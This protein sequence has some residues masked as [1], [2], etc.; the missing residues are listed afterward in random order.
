MHDSDLLSTI[1]SP[2][3]I[4]PLKQNS[5]LPL[6]PW[7]NREFS[8]FD[9]LPGCNRAIVI[10]DDYCVLD[11]EGPGKQVS[12]ISHLQGL[13]QAHG[14]LPETLCWTTPSGGYAYLFKCSVPVEHKSLARTLGLELRTGQHYHLI[15]DSVVNGKPYR[16]EPVGEIAEIPAWL[17]DVFEAARTPLRSQESSTPSKQSRS[18]FIF[19]ALQQLNPTCSYEQWVRIGMACKAGGLTLE[20]W[21]QW[22]LKGENKCEDEAEYTRK[23]NSFTKSGVSEGTLIHMAMQTRW[24]PPREEVHLPAPTPKVLPEERFL[25]SFPEP[26]GLLKELKDYFLEVSKQEQYSL[27]AALFCMNVV[28]QRSYNFVS[29][30]QNSYHVFIGESGAR[31]STVMDTCFDVLRAVAPTLEMQDPRSVASF[32]KQLAEN[33]SRALAI[34]EIGFELNRALYSRKTSQQTED[35][36]KEILKMHGRPSH[37]AGHGTAKKED[38]V[39]GVLDPRISLCAT[40]TQSDFEE[41]LSHKD[42]VDTGLFSRFVVWRGLELPVSRFVF[43]QNKKTVPPDLVERLKR[44]HHAFAV[45]NTAWAPENVIVAHDVENYLADFKEREIDPLYAKHVRAR[46]LVERSFYQGIQFAYLHALGRDAPCLEVLDTEWGSEVALQV[47][48]QSLEAFELYEKDAVDLAIEAVLKFIQE[49]GARNW[50]YL[51]QSCRAV[52]KLDRKM[53]KEV[54]DGL[55]LTGQVWKNPKD[56]LITPF[57]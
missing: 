52:R 51:E 1:L 48:K 12:G 19:E 41:L 44:F 11:V 14:D 49:R 15:P 56:G 53:R 42:F 46:S 7:T 37:L 20:D 9:F 28:T 23:W 40:A 6:A 29:A 24:E 33:P 50:R 5:K 25:A 35:K 3:K 34:D 18:D 55:L 43:G 13:M 54:H 36:F 21:K 4:I 38:S 57:H 22:S 47:L 32:K 26:Q 27:G 2:F 45:A 39:V 30:P 16:W 10:G 8:P 17:V 31:K